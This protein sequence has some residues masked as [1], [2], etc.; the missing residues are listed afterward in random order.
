MNKLF[1]KIDPKQILK[2]LKR[3]GLLSKML[4]DVFSILAIT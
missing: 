1:R 3:I 4:A 2:F